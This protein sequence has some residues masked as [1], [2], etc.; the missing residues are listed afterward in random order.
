MLRFFAI[1]FDKIDILPLT[2][3]YQMQNFVNFRSIMRKKIP[4]KYY[5]NVGTLATGQK[6]GV[7][8]I[9]AGR[10]PSLIKQEFEHFQKIK[11]STLSDTF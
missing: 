9:L 8:I 3:A 6:T 5:K 4:R 1:F 11:K 7:Q 10:V 2:W